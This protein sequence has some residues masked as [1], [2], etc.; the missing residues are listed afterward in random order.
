[1][2][3]EMVEAAMVLEVV[4]AEMVLVMVFEVVE[5]VCLAEIQRLLAHRVLLNRVKH[6]G[7]IDALLCLQLCLEDSVAQHLL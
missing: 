1:M 2:V 7:E 3:L 4:E 5:A 6:L